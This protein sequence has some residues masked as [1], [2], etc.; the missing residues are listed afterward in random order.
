MGVRGSGTATVGTDGATGVLRD[1]LERYLGGTDSELAR[2]LL[3]E[4]RE[5][6]TVRIDPVRLYTWDFTPRMTDLSAAPSV[7]QGEPASP[8]YGHTGK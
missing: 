5:E 6:A 8:E 3:R 2:W 1:L 7:T 4:E